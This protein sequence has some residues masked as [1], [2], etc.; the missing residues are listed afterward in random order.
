MCPTSVVNGAGALDRRGLGLAWH[1]QAKILTPLLTFLKLSATQ[2]HKTV[3][4]ASRTDARSAAPA[5]RLCYTL[6]CVTYCVRI[7][8][9]PRRMSTA[10]HKVHSCT[11]Y[12]Y[13]YYW[14]SPLDLSSNC[15]GTV[16][17]RYYNCTVPVTVPVTI[18]LT[19]PVVIGEMYPSSPGLPYMRGFPRRISQVSCWHC[20][21]T[22]WGQTC[23]CDNTPSC[24]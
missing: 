16:L 10:S 8:T 1:D 21:S 20:V 12:R 3:T 22:M 4:S 14:Y 13:R 11:E 15:T 24:P 17:C 7:D 9:C 2:G 23:S 5:A 18:P 19:V 6:Q